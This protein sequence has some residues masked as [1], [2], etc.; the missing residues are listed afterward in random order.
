MYQRDQLGTNVF[1]LCTLAEFCSKFLFYQKNNDLN[2]KLT[3]CLKTYIL[4]RMYI[5]T[6]FSSSLYYY[7]ILQQITYILRHTQEHTVHMNLPMLKVGFVLQ[8]NLSIYY[9]NDR[10]HYIYRLHLSY[11]FYRKRSFDCLNC[12]IKG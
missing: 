9:K 1:Y 4:L 8:H 10:K 3:M 2:F 12:L 5:G 7:N 6:H 11:T